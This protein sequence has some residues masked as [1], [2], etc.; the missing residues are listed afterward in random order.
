MRTLFGDLW[1]PGS[2]V[3]AYAGLIANSTI[4]LA[5]GI[6]LFSAAGLARLWSRVSL[7]NVTYR[8]E[9]SERRAFVGE[10][11]EFNVY[12][13]NDKAIP[14]PWIEIRELIPDE[15]IVTGGRT[16]TSGIPRMHMLL[17]HTSLRRF[18]RL[19][20]PMRLRST[21]RGYFRVGPTRLRSGDLF[22]FF[23]REES[24]PAKDALVVY[25]KTYPLPELG[26]DSVR[27]FGDQRGGLRIYEDPARV[28]GVRDYTPGDPMRRVDW[29]ATARVGRLQ[30]RLYEPSRAQSLVVALN[31][32]TMEQTWQGFD[33]VLLERGVS[34][35][36]SIATWG[37]E[38]GS[39]VG[40][41]AN[42]S[43]PDADRPLRI[44][45]G[46]RP[47]QLGT[48]LETL[49]MIS[50]YTT[51]LLSQELESREHGLPAGTT[52]VVVAALMP[53]TLAATVQRLRREG[54]MVHVVKISA[55]PWEEPLDGVPMSDIE[56]YLRGIEDEEAEI[57]AAAGA[58][59]AA[60]P[61]AVRRERTRP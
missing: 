36:A 46:R 39:A 33:P 21:A 25:P 6:L 13:T 5:L 42:G 11:L 44:G 1:L 24:V 43:F 18:E 32:T 30:S 23:E 7:E 22:G 38:Q 60:R 37:I 55:A 49:A 48:L 29:K 53:R 9:I 8:R 45:S 61:G 31:I 35:A 19:K 50:P 51:S 47:E 2:V 17:R 28:I 10:T 14:V 59:P 12:L 56:P 58:D 20:W 26:F 52:I 57:E 27:P 34:V 41:I 15:M 16:Q 4:V 54:H 40:L 3:I